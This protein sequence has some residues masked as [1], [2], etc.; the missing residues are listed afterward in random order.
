MVQT[1][2]DPPERLSRDS[3]YRVLQS[4]LGDLVLRPWFDWVALNSVAR[5]YFPLSRAW[6]AAIGP[7]SGRSWE[8]PIGCGPSRSRC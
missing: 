8:S 1:Y 6:A 7:A 2:S 5:G 4:G 3:R